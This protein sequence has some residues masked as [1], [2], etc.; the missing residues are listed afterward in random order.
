MAASTAA[1]MVVSMAVWVASLVVMS[2]VEMEP[3]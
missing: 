3:S 1:L 2:V